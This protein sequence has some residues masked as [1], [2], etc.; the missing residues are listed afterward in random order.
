M[1]DIANWL[2]QSMN[3]WN[4]EYIWFILLLACFF[5]VLFLHRYFGPYG[6]Y[7]YIAV[8]II[9]ANI[10]VLKAVQFNI[11]PEPVALGTILFSSTY[12]ATD[13]LGEQFGLKFARRGVYMGFF[14][15]LFFSVIM[16]LTLGFSPLTPEQAGENMA[17]AIPYHDHIAALFTLQFSLFSAGILAYFISQLNDIWLYDW[18]K[19]KTNNKYLWLR[20]NGSTIVS[21]LIDNT[22]FSIFAWIIFSSNP[23]PF[24]TVLFTYILGTYS[25][26]IFIALLDTPVMYL[27]KAWKYQGNEDFNSN[28]QS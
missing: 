11:F 12:L 6:L 25:L 16:L 20:N 10:Q 7:A 28:I 24:K 5:F 3:Q 13:L 18:I 27:A 2:I 1:N 9:S 14:A 4:P 8:A 26:R 22:V 15:H 17:W 23:L 21:A 19:R